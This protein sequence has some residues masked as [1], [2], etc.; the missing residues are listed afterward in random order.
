MSNTASPRRWPPDN[1]EG[2]TDPPAPAPNVVPIRVNGG[3]D[4][5][6]SFSPEGDAP[7]A[8]T[9]TPTPSKKVSP[10]VKTKWL[11]AFG[12]CFAAG[13][14]AA[15]VFYMWD[16]IVPPQAQAS[17][18][19]G[20]VVLRS[21][22]DGAAVLID[23]I[24]RGV[25]PLEL[26]LMP[27]SHDV[28]FRA[29]SAERRI[30]LKVE[31]GARVAENVDMPAVPETGSLEV[32]S[33]PSG[34]KVSVDGTAVGVTPLSLAGVSPARHAVVV[35]QG[36]SNVTRTVDVTAG[37]ASNVF[38][39][40]S[41]QSAS[42]SG[43]LA[44]ESPIELRIL[45]NGQ[46]LGLSNGAPI[47]LSSGK[48]QIDLVNET[49][50]LHLNRS[51]TVDAGKTARLAV[52]IP[53]GTLS[54]NASPWAEVFVDGRSI[55]LTPLGAVSIPVGSHEVV[56]RHPQFGEKRRTVVVGAQ[57]TTRVTMDMNR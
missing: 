7:P 44:I 50:E 17:P 57:A 56:W 26:E 14:L 48:H 3:E 21:R 23:G 33:E 34:A 20:H 35:S 41:A 16:R 24:S 40:L 19:S 9:S 52:T 55:G 10:A 49:L 45:E 12:A 47:V 30:D 1:A 4:P 8:P 42:A 27:G 28:V 36:G 6:A 29:G 53:S 32:T 15:A 37:A 46:L 43:T 22:P 11:I 2:P 51:L 5:L 31:G 18:L 54:V 25:T 39:A 38:V 13:A